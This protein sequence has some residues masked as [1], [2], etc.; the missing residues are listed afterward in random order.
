[1]TGLIDDAH[2]GAGHGREDQT[3]YV[4]AHRLQFGC[5][6]VGAP[7]QKGGGFQPAR[8]DPLLRLFLPG[9]EVFP[10]LA[11]QA[12]LHFGRGFLRLGQGRDFQKDVD[13]PVGQVLL[14]VR[15]IGQ[16]M[17]EPFPGIVYPGNFPAD[18][19]VNR[20]GDGPD[21]HAAAVD[22]GQGLH[23]FGMF[24]G[25]ATGLEAA[26]GVPGD[27]R[28]TCFQRPEKTMG[29]SHGAAD[30]IVLIV[31]RVVGKAQ[32]DLVY[33][34]DVK[35]PGEQPDVPV[36]DI[37][38]GSQAEMGAVHQEQRLPPASLQVPGPD[39]VYVDVFGFKDGGVPPVRDAGSP[40]RNPGVRL[41]GRP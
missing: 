31:F 26:A 6:V 1:M 21:S 24:Q 40:A 28:R 27:V 5:R 39:A 17:P 2:P 22:D 7:D 16:L 38:A 18:D 29:V 10:E 13:E 14:A 11:L 37:G 19:V 32:A 33:S 23:G 34:Q 3:H 20:H 36:P 12:G 8:F 30:D 35:V 41:P 25:Q 9:G 15:V 4:H